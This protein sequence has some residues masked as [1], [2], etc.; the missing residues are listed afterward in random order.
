MVRPQLATTEASGFRVGG[1]LNGGGEGER[2]LLTQRPHQRLQRE[3]GLFNSQVAKDRFF[4]FF[5]FKDASRVLSRQRTEVTF[6]D[7]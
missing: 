7:E 4:F 2:P 6:R 5:F 1:G 3:P